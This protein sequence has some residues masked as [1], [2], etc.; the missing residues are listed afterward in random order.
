M[1]TNTVLNGEFYN[2]N[3][4]IEHTRL[5]QNPIEYEVTLHAIQRTLD[6]ISETGTKS[7]KILDLGGGTGR[8]GRFPHFSNPNHYTKITINAAIDLA[9][10]GHSVTLS[11]I[12][13]SELDIAIKHAK[14]QKVELAAIAKVDAREVRAS[15]LFKESHY[16]IVLCLGPFYHLLL[17][18]ERTQLLKDCAA[19]TKFGGYVL[20]AFITKYAHLRDLANKD[21][22]RLLGEKHFY[23]KYLQDGQ[24]TRNPN[25]SSHHTNT[26]EIQQLF[27][28]NEEL[29]LEKLIA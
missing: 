5:V 13:S 3:A 18:E 6:M 25:S 8:Y 28:G 14:T 9:K 20:A 27:Q 22:G 29:K 11:D 17:E 15:L 12:S 4:Q 19:M 1:A 10:L 2:N 21:P 16:D 26:V 7:C 23:D 24:Y